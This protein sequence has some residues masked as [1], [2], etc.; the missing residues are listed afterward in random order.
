MSEVKEE[1]GMQSMF[2]KP[3][4][5]DDDVEGQIQSEYPAHMMNAQIDS[6]DNEINELS[7]DL[8]GGRI[9]GG[10]I[11]EAKE[12]LALLQN[13]FDDIVISKPN[14]TQSEEK[15]LHDEL[16]KMN[17]DMADTL[18]SRYDQQKGKGSIARPQQEADLNDKPCIEINPEVARICNISGVVNGKAS[19]NMID[20]AR[21]ILCAYFGRDDASREAIRPENQT[22]RKRPMVGYN[23]PAFAKAHDRIFGKKPEIHPSLLEDK[24]DTPESIQAEI[25]ALQRKIARIKEAGEQKGNGEINTIKPEIETPERET[26]TD[27][28]YV[29]PE[30]ECGFVGKLTQKGAHI[31]MHNKQKEIEA[32]RLKEE[33]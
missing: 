33:E 5:K 21:K 8:N 26:K 3:D 25:T 16:L 6:L 13:K 2:G 23:S 9:P 29:C 28:Q 10:D 11:F 32:N 18:Y 7:S 1:V 19:R 15:F 12:E 20:K 30:P 31:R 4:R 24:G 14:Y 17:S 27:K 22:T